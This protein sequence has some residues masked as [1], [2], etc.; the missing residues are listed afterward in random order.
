M[1]STFEETATGTHGKRAHFER[2][3]EF[4]PLLAAARLS[5]IVYSAYLLYLRTLDNTEYCVMSTC[6]ADV[7]TYEWS[8][9]PIEGFQGDMW[10]PRGSHGAPPIIT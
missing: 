6:N 8:N 1:A 7:A 4:R 9:P 10:M 5:S 2:V 3:F